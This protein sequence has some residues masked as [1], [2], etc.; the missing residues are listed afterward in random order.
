[1][2]LRGF[3]HLIFGLKKKTLT[4]SLQQSG[5]WTVEFGLC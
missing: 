3:F 2:G 1:M 4:I 5:Y